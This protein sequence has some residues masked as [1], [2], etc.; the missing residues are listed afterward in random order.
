M[1]PKRH[2]RSNPNPNPPSIVDDLEKILRKLKSPIPTST[3]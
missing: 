3:T 1:A 2:T